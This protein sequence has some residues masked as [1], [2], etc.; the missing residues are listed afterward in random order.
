MFTSYCVQFFQEE[1]SK[2]FRNSTAL[3]L[4][5]LFFPFGINSTV[6]KCALW[7]NCT[8]I[9][10]KSHYLENCLQYYLLFQ[11]HA[12]KQLTENWFGDSIML[13]QM[14]QRFETKIYYLST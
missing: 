12:S 4:D 2:N 6:K 5:S 1:V 13:L 14:L 9:F 8:Y 3:L 7:E 10:I 11:G